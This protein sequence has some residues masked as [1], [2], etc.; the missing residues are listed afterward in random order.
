VDKDK[1]LSNVFVTALYRPKALSAF[2]GVPNR[3]PKRPL[4]PFVNVVPVVK[5]SAGVDVAA[6]EFREGA[7]VG[8][9]LSVV[10]ISLVSQI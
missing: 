3:P 1:L 4:V 5:E 10:F 8:P 9:N 6:G 7:A 2:A